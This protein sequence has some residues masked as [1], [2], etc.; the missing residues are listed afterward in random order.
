MIQIIYG[1]PEDGMRHLNTYYCV[2]CEKYFYGF[3]PHRCKDGFRKKKLKSIMIVA[4]RRVHELK[5]WPEYFSLHCR[6]LKTF[7]IRNNDR[8]FQVGDSLVL[9]EYFPE[10]N[11]YSGR[12][13]I[14][15]VKDIFE[16][17]KLGLEPGFV[18]ISTG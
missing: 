17:G 1:Y 15:P 3:I 14:K 4:D 5:I 10:L 13:I 7:E 12:S 18:I 16:G 11:Q 8:N 6:G 9:K 2:L